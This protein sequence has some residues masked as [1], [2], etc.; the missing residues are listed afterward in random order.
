MWKIEGPAAYQQE[1]GAVVRN[2]GDVNGDSL[3]DVAVS[4][5][6]Y[7][8]GNWANSGA[9]N[10]YAGTATGV[11]ALLASHLSQG[12]TG[13]RFGQW[14]STGADLNG[15]GRSDFVVGVPTHDEISANNTI[16]DAGAALTIYGDD[17]FNRFGTGLEGGDINGDGYDD[18]LV[19]AINYDNGQGDAGRLWWFFGSPNGLPLNPAGYVVGDGA[20]QSYFGDTIVS[21]GDL[22]A[23]GYED[24]VVA[25]TA[26]G[27]IAKGK[28]YLY[29]GSETGLVEQAWSYEYTE[30]WGGFLGQGFLSA[31]DIDGD[32]YTDIAAGARVGWVGCSDAGQVLVFLGGASGFAASPDVVLR[33]SECPYTYATFGDLVDVNGDGFDDVVAG[34]Y[35]ADTAVGT[36][37]G[38]VDVYLGSASGPAS[39]ADMTLQQPLGGATGFGRGVRGVSDIN[40]DGFE[41]LVVLSDSPYDAA[42]GRGRGYV[43]TGSSGGLSATATSEFWGLASSTVHVFG[44]QHSLQPAG[45]LNGD[46]YPD[47][48][49][50]S[51]LQLRAYA[52]L[53]SES[54][55]FPTWAWGS[56]GPASIVNT[57]GE[58]ATANHDFDADGNPD[59]VIGADRGGNWAGGVYVYMGTGGADLFYDA[60][61]NDYQCPDLDLDSIC[62]ASDNC[63]T[64]ANPNQEDTDN[65][66]VGDACDGDGDGIPNGLDNCD[67]I[68]N[69]G[70]ED[71]DGDLIGDACD[72]DVDGDGDPATSDCDDTNPN[73][74]TGATELCDSLDN[75][76]DT[77]VDEGIPCGG[78]N[79]NDS[80]CDGV[81]DD[82]DGD[83]DEDCQLARSNSGGG[84]GPY[85]PI[86]AFDN[87]W[88]SSDSCFVANRTSSAPVGTLPGSFSVSDTGAA[89]YSIPLSITPGRQGM[90]P[91][92]SLKYNSHSG[93]GILG[94]GWSLVASS[95]I[96]RCGKTRHEDSAFSSPYLVRQDALC[97]N[98]TRLVELGPGETST[99]PSESGMILTELRT[100]S[101]PFDR[102]CAYS[103]SEGY[104]YG[105]KYF[106]I[107]RKNTQIE[108][109]GYDVLSFVGVMEV[110]SEPLHFAYVA[111]PLTKREDRRGNQ[112]IYEYKT[113]DHIHQTL[114]GLAQIL[115]NFVTDTNPDPVYALTRIRYTLHDSITSSDAERRVEVVYE[116]RPDPSDGYFKGV[117][118][119]SAYRVGA[120]NVYGRCNERVGAYKMRYW[121]EGPYRPL[122]HL[123]TVEYCDSLDVCM[124]PTRFEWAAAPSIQFTEM[125][126]GGPVQNIQSLHRSIFGGSVHLMDLLG[127]GRAQAVVPN[128]IGGPNVDLHV[129]TADGSGNMIMPTALTSIVHILGTNGFFPFDFDTD[130]RDEAIGIAEAGPAAGYEALQ[131]WDFDSSGV[132]SLVFSTANGFSVGGTDYSI[133]S[134]LGRGDFDGNGREELLVRLIHDP[135]N[136]VLGADEY[137]G[138]FYYNPSAAIPGFELVVAG[139]VLDD[140]LS[141]TLV[142]DF[143]GDGRDVLLYY[144]DPNKLTPHDEGYRYVDSQGDLFGNWIQYSASGDFPTPYSEVKKIATND[145]QEEFTNMWPWDANG[146]GLIDLLIRRIQLDA[147][148]EN[149]AV[150]DLWLNTGERFESVFQST[151]LGPRLEF[152]DFGNVLQTA[153][154]GHIAQYL[155]DIDGDGGQELLV[156][157]TEPGSPLATLS[158]LSWDTNTVQVQPVNLQLEGGLGTA[159]PFL[160]NRVTL[161]DLDDDGFDELILPEAAADG[162]PGHSG[163][164]G[165]IAFQRQTSI[166]GVISSIRTGL[167]TN[168]ADDPDVSI[169]YRWTTRKDVYDR[170]LLESCGPFQSCTTPAMHVAEFVTVATAIATP[171]QSRKVST[172]Y[173]YRD[174]RRDLYG[175]GFLGFGQVKKFYA[176]SVTTTSRYDL[177][178]FDIGLS[179]YPFVAKVLLTTVDTSVGPTQT[180][181]TTIEQTPEL[182]VL[183]GGNSFT[184]FSKIHRSTY[185]FGQRD[186]FM[187]HTIDYSVTGES[188]RIRNIDD[189]GNVTQEEAYWNTQPFSTLGPLQNDAW[190]MDLMTA[191][192]LGSAAQAT[193]TYEP[194]DESEWLVSRVSEVSTLSKSSVCNADQAKDGTVTFPPWH[195]GDG[196]S[197]GGQARE[198]VKFY[199]RTATGEEDLVDYIESN[200]NI[201]SAATTTTLSYDIYGNVIQAAISGVGDYLGN[202][203]T[204]VTTMSYD[205]LEHS[206]PIE[207]VNARGQRER[208]LYDWGLGLPVAT[209]GVDGVVATSSRDGF[210]RISESGV[211]GGDVITVAYSAPPPGQSLGLV[212]R[213]DLGS[214]S[215]VSATSDIY[216]NLVERRRA[217]FGGGI[218]SQ[219]FGYD[220]LRRLVSIEVPHYTSETPPFETF[221]ASYDIL[222]R[223]TTFDGADGATTYSYDGITR[224]VT[225][226]RGK[227]T[228]QIFNV[229]GQLVASVD[230]VGNANRYY[231]SAY[232]SLWRVLDAAGS[233]TG[234]EYSRPNLIAVN[235]DSVGRRTSLRDPDLGLRQYEYNA[236][237]E[238]VTSVDAL[239]NVTHR[240]Y[241][242]LGRTIFQ[243]DADGQTLWQWDVGAGAGVGKIAGILA[244]GGHSE[245]FTYDSYGRT[246]GY[247]V[248]VNASAGLP[249]S[250]FSLSLDYDDFGRLTSTTYPVV[251][252]AP[253]IRASHVYDSASGL[254]LEVLGEEMGNPGTL[255]SLWLSQ[256]VNA[257]DQVLQE[258]RGNG[259]ETLRSFDPRS[260]RLKTIESSNVQGVFRS[261]M[262]EH[263][264]VGNVIERHYQAGSAGSLQDVYHETA[265]YDD[266]GRLFEVLDLTSATPSIPYLSIV[267]DAVGN[268]ISRSDKGSYTY[269]RTQPHA[270]RQV[271]SQ[272]FD[273]DANGNQVERNGRLLS[274]TAFEKIQTAELDTGGEVQ[275]SY[276]GGGSRLLKTV[277]DPVGSVVKD[278]VYVLDQLAQIEYGSSGDHAVLNVFGPGAQIVA[279]YKSDGLTSWTKS[280]PHH[281]N[282]GSVT[283]LTDQSGNTTHQWTYDVFGKR[284]LLAGTSGALCDLGYTGHTEDDELGLVHAPLS[285]V[286]SQHRTF[287]NSGCHHSELWLYPGV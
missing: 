39:V 260:L 138:V 3:E 217:G 252:T 33:P 263:D 92:L 234:G 47:F 77:S 139:H 235:Y 194:H 129:F 76:C 57:F 213:Q 244:P 173:D 118:T 148:G 87:I 11:G 120:I 8:V 225:D 161:F 179:V 15:D 151:Y 43:F 272:T 142:G 181:L 214:G 55:T 152:P 13:S 171:G 103:L 210:G 63:P 61:V 178:T 94:K 18:L 131:V 69:P 73:R 163:I 50:G 86:P 256:N 236:F 19:G 21:L 10:V 184:T 72:G 253:Q 49:V 128:L 99:C 147:S 264:D 224:S 66:G 199:Y 168:Y 60:I 169:N 14:I 201:P 100:K 124:P 62:Y 52:F 45:D 71:L 216:G 35:Q 222:G 64:V 232:G 231:Y 26:Y 126:G 30:H 110:P 277:T 271:G 166:S 266:V 121:E 29:H 107:Y 114:P 206:F 265:H 109:Y 115:P 182:R 175:H 1:H 160:S 221:T 177:A 81:D 250:T 154:P 132:G 9:V 262:F 130:G 273:Y 227:T 134:I 274:Y 218:V 16:V 282:L 116:T 113:A 27:S 90:Q 78:G 212:V 240:A 247:G 280:Y 101:D 159:P 287:S 22:N 12:Q 285:D 242:T 204:R 219:S 283:E 5:P 180:S 276:T 97:W 275:F 91:S 23:D 96:R 157:L 164:Y 270:V 226:A 54:V 258:V 202:I 198:R 83:I 111:W 105:P 170:T 192:A 93:D 155:Q 51:W 245:T 207:S 36:K 257:R 209:Q 53:G 34:A 286:R 243:E 195:T 17:M 261:F 140:I 95:E 137:L 200:S 146:D 135:Q 255:G 127:V 188:I 143:N 117:K 125:P 112:I 229:L 167:N 46:G 74:Y 56:Q 38:L 141:S 59:V 249:Q 28:F 174:A 40:Q 82:T 65:D 75:D 162:F 186:H 187:D 248:T 228:H 241:D 84:A 165:P 267:F 68:S 172:R 191:E 122:S 31:G 196:C 67:A 106:R 104:S 108:T 278:V 58:H 102:I 190:L 80:T 189:F 254:L 268:I 37:A 24:F 70:Q 205:S 136:Y 183:N 145:G 193:T 237:G 20:P 158:F 215:W 230:A 119:Q 150:I 176:N 25:A 281:D 133:R 211:A 279:S 44:T 6:G 4:I 149:E 156:R 48:V 197:D 88:S 251:G 32:G 269:T 185:E 79:G 85:N 7:V 239:S 223:P 208:A 203:Q 233:E 144:R 246:M 41:D 284:T 238:L 2:V 42:K 123:E 259:V 153:G 89:T 98:G 220:F